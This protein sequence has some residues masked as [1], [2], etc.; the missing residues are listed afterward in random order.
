MVTST[1]CIGFPFSPKVI[2]PC[3][4]PP[5]WGSIDKSETS[6]VVRAVSRG[7]L[8]MSLEWEV[9]LVSA[10]GNA[11]EL[12]MKTADS[13]TVSRNADL[14]VPMIMIVPFSI[15][16]RYLAMRCALAQIDVQE[17]AS[18]AEVASYLGRASRN[19]TVL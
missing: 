11:V 8:A 3:N 10:W 14:M 4:V 18:Q 17:I 16:N 6:C 5:D 9:V 7:G 2:V 19:A 15:V 12:R 13:P 1:L